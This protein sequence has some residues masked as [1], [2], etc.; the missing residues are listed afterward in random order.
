MYYRL[1]NNTLRELIKRDRRAN[2]PS[3]NL[4]NCTRWN[5]VGERYEMGVYFPI[6]RKPGKSKSKS[7]KVISLK[8]VWL[9]KK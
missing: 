3:E 2:P 8:R 9:W 4:S 6:E 7:Y 5:V 1:A